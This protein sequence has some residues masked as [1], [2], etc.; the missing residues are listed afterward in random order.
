MYHTFDIISNIMGYASLFVALA[1]F[2]K[3]LYREWK[4]Q[5]FRFTLSLI[6]HGNLDEKDHARA[7]LG[8]HSFLSAKDLQ[9]ALKKGRSAP[10]PV[11][12]FRLDLYLE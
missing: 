3:W 2:I 4:R 8:K 5:S 9:K 12:V 1:I 6:E 10:R 11:K 7:M